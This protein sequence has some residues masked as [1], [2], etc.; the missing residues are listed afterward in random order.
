MYATQSIS[1]IHGSTLDV[2]VGKELQEPVL[3]LRTDR[4]TDQCIGGVLEMTELVLSEKQ[5][6]VIRWVANSQR[7]LFLSGAVRSGK[8]FSINLAWLL[9]TQGKF[10]EPQHFILAGFSVSSI[11]RNLFPDMQA[12]TEALGMTWQYHHTGSYVQCGMHRY[13]LFGSSDADA[14]DKV[15]GMTAAGAYMD[16]MVLM[17]PDFISMAISR[18]SVPGAKLMG[19]MNPDNPGH[20]IKTDY[21][22]RCDGVT[23]STIKFGLKDNPSLT[24]EYIEWL[25]ATLTGADYQRLVEGE[26]CANSGLVYPKFEVKPSPTARPASHWLLL[27]YSTS[28]TIAMLLADRHR[29]GNTHIRAEYY[30]TAESRSGGNV[31]ASDQ[32]TD[33]EIIRDLRIFLM[34]HKVPTERIIILPDPS[35]ASLKKLLVQEGFDVRVAKNNILD[36]IRVTNTALG[37]GKITIDPGCKTLQKELHTYHWDPKA[38]AIGEDKPLKTD[39]HHGVD[40]LRYYAL[41]TYTYLTQYHGVIQKPGGW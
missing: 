24:Q 4:F 14:V 25:K 2:E 16:E 30:H 33:A 32:K 9:W 35:A 3:S 7:M 22:D 36:G 37:L 18:L 29:D 39:K 21:I 26:W 17:H 15:R 8:T 6:Q 5:K 40:A 20:Y 27:D 23:S 28:G 34:G 12:L 19:S 11:R 31:M 38:S 1:C 10:A 13:H 41:K